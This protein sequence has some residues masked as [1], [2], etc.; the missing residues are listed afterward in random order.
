MKP[1]LWKLY[2]QMLYSRLFEQKVAQLWKQGLISGEMHLGIG[3]EGIAA[4]VAAHLQDGDAL[5]LDHRGTPPL[6]MRGVSPSL[7]LKEFLGFND[8]ICSGKGGH[9]HLFSPEHLAASS[10]IVGA[11]GPA[12]VGLAL[13]ARYLRP[14][15]LSVAFFGEGSVNQGM[16]MESFNLASAWQLPVLFVC[17]DSEWSISTY[18]AGLTAGNLNERLRSFGLPVL[19]VDGSD[20]EA[21]WVAA[22]EA[23]EYIR[24]GN[25]AYF[26]LARCYHPEGHF[27]GDPIVRLTRSPWRESRKVVPAIMKSLFRRGGA[28]FRKRVE[29]LFMFLS[30]VAR[31]S[32]ANRQTSLD[33]VIKTRNKLADQPNRLEDLELRV[34]RA[35][36]EV[37]NGEVET[38]ERVRY[39]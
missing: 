33:P 37:V 24:R 1:D 7:L 22:A 12:A 19:E 25:G 6:L 26:L 17:K 13:A 38:L 21:V 3:E 8:G 16:L 4:G 34:K 5:A 9:M 30:N 35:V 36:A 29:G 10:G 23:V 14:G 2:E 20:V 11:S 18:S 32:R 39:A 31:A 27:L 28:P 15:N